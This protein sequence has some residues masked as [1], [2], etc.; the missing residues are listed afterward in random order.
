M[1]FCRRSLWSQ[2]YYGN[3]RSATKDLVC[4]SYAPING[5]CGTG[6]ASQES[7]YD[8]LCW[9]E[10]EGPPAIWHIIAVGSTDYTDRLT[11]QF[12]AVRY[13]STGHRET[14]WGPNHNGAIAVA[15]GAAG[16]SSNAVAYDGENLE[17]DQSDGR[18]YA[19]GV[20]TP[21]TTGA[22]FV[23]VRWNVDG[24]LDTNFG[25]GGQV[26]LDLGTSTTA[27]S[28]TA[29]GIKIMPSS[30]GYESYADKISIGGYTGPTTAAGR[31]GLAQFLPDNRVTVN[32][33]GS[34]GAPLGP[35][36]SGSTAA[37]TDAPAGPTSLLLDGQSDD[38]LSS[39]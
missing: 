3:V 25:T 12:A 9:R 16:P 34:P 7:A 29:R 14:T 35:V 23:A 8:L 15:S 22:D 21:G 33:A 6:Y 17:F 30:S 39:A 18:F 38:L 5:C 24:T 26:Q 36:F 11:N 4:S 19:A 32:A 20:G 13:D 1:G 27:Y 10:T 2:C 31:I 37:P 28:D